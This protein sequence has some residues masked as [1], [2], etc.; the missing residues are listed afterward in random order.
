MSMFIIIL[1]KKIN[2]MC[3]VIEQNHVKDPSYKAE[4]L[5]LYMTLNFIIFIIIYC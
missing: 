4:Y 5:N 3:K 2:F 1:L